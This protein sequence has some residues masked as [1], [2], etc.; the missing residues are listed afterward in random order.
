[1][2]ISAIGLALALI[3][4]GASGP[5]ETADAGGDVAVVSD[6][7]SS[8]DS[9]TCARG[10]ALVD[11]PRCASYSDTN[12]DGVVCRAGTHCNVDTDAAGRGV[13]VCE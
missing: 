13:V 2:R 6:A 10:F 1:M 9:M 4:C 11:G 7:P 3:G 5:T 12:C 8:A